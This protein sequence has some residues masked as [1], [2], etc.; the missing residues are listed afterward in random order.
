MLVRAAEGS[1][2][3]GERPGR[4]GERGYKRQREKRRNEGITRTG[5]AKR[6]E[7]LEKWREQERES[8]RGYACEA[9]KTSE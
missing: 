3:R 1:M 4:A 2:G 8:E 5:G 6:K 9:L 7:K